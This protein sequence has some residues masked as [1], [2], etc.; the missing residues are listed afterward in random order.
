M[1]LHNFTDDGVKVQY[2]IAKS[3]ES[4]KKLLVLIH[5][6]GADYS[7]LWPFA[8]E[9]QKEIP[10]LECI[11]PNGLEPCDEDKTYRQWFRMGDWNID[12]LK[13]NINIS[14]IKF[15]K[16]LN[17]IASKY[18]MSLQDIIL[19]GFSQGTMMALHNGILDNVCGILGYSGMIVDDNILRNRTELPKILM[20]H[21]EAD[22]VVPLSSL[23][24][25]V[26][27]FKENGFDLKY[28][29][30][31]R[32]EHMIETKGLNKGIEFIKSLI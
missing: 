29:I 19:M 6:Y 13:K 23:I 28:E 11:L 16:F 2:G 4:P 10:F 21:G 24:N 32:A 25:S 27:L 5:G 14:G 26:D 12:E 9:I 1:D 31:P 15:S 22:N 8:I 17:F 18:N 30:I 20:I 3:K 7:D